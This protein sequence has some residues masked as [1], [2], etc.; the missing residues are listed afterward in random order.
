MKWLT[1]QRLYEVH[2]VSRKGQE[3]YTV[4]MTGEE[5]R[6][7]CKTKNEAYG[8]IEGCGGDKSYSCW[9]V[10]ITGVGY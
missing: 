7:W 9:A 8:Y 4:L 2:E 10:Q 1:E 5:I 3:V 6:Q